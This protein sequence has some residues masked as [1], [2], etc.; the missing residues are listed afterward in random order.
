[1]CT[2]TEKAWEMGESNTFSQV[3]HL[4]PREQKCSEAPFSISKDSTNWSRSRLG[5]RERVIQITC[6]LWH[7][8]SLLPRTWERG[9][10][11]QGLWV[12][13]SSRDRVW[14]RPW[15]SFS[16]HGSPAPLVY[17]TAPA[18]EHTSKPAFWRRNDYVQ[19]WNFSS[20]Q[21]YHLE[22]QISFKQIRPYR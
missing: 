20:A 1:M 4:H 9:S 12:P 11:A 15:P 10:G 13:F 7:L 8:G 21:I 2:S 17:S 3:L 14:P 19:C 6:A 5:R 18:A 22:I 16:P